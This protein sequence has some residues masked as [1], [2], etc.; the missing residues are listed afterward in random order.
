VGQSGKGDVFTFGPAVSANNRIDDPGGAVSGD[1]PPGIDQFLVALASGSPA[2]ADISAPD[3]E[4]HASL[5]LLVD[6]HSTGDKT[7]GFSIPSGAP[8][9]AV[10]EIGDDP[11]Y[12]RLAVTDLTRTRTFTPFDGAPTYTETEAFSRR[13]RPIRPP[14]IEISGVVD[15]DTGEVVD[16]VEVYRV[17]YTLYDPGMPACD[18]RWYDAST[19]TWHFDSGSIHEVT[20]RLTSYAGRGFDF[21]QGA[22]ADG[23]ASFENFSTGLI[24]ESTSQIL[25]GNC[26]DGN[27]GPSV[28]TPQERAC[29]N[30]QPAGTNPMPTL[31]LPLSTAVI[32]GF[33]PVE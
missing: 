32:S 17:T 21:S 7:G 11:S 1:I 12:L 27:C 6:D 20:L 23:D 31:G 10:D 25:D 9:T 4:F 24:H 14:R 30:N 28:P 13:T 16:G 19:E 8:K 5:Y 15:A 33:T 22:A 2:E 3:S 18:P 29:D 26:E